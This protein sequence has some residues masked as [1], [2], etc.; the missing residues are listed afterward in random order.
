ML[1]PISQTEL[2]KFLTAVAWTIVKV[3]YVKDTMFREDLFQMLHFDLCTFT[4]QSP[5]DRK[6]AVVV[7]RAVII[8]DFCRTTL[9]F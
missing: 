9:A 8:G 4:F 2:T 7:T 3:E 5:Q 6:F 1:E